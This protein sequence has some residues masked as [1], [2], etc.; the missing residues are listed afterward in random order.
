MAC[1]SPRQAECRTTC[2]IISKTR[3]LPPFVALRRSG[4]SIIGGGTGP[5]TGSFRATGISAY[6]KN[7]G[8]LD[9]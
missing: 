9:K 5:R 6:L 4:F 1:V 8:T 2:L 3:P 7:G